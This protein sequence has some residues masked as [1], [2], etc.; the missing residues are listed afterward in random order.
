MRTLSLLIALTLVIP[1]AGCPDDSPAS[2]DGGTSGADGTP[3]GADGGGGPVTADTL[4]AACLRFGSCVPDDGINACLRSYTDDGDA[5]S[6]GFSCL[7]ASSACGGLKAC[8]GLWVKVGS[9]CAAG[10]HD[11]KCLDQSTSYGCDDQ[12]GFYI[13]CNRWFGASCLS[14]GGGG[15]CATGQS[16]TG[17]ARS[18]KG[19]SVV[20]CSGGAEV[21][22]EPCAQLGL[23]CSG[24]QC[25]GDG[26]ACTAGRCDGKVAVR[27]IGGKESKLDC[28]GLG[29]GWSCALSKGEARC[30]QG[31]AC[32][33]QDSKRKETCEGT[34]VV[35]CHGGKT[36]KVDCTAHGF[37]SCQKG[38]CLP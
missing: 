14:S 18:C 22:E 11:Q 30:R 34:K 38:L 15:N 7:A 2:S 12:Y 5:F 17:T 16:C 35:L 20:R 19:G 33:P 6:A 29:A 36:V 23:G 31:S 25:A 9:P 26:P 3:P 32:D 8:T 10:S 24:G 27:C 1:L 13:D 4:L 21:H 37:S 28:A